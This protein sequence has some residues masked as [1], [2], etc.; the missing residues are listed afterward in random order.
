MESVQNFDPVLRKI[1]Y[2]NEVQVVSSVMKEI[3]NEIVEISEHLERVPPAS[4]EIVEE[5]T[6]RLNSLMVSRCDILSRL[7]KLL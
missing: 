3:A 7:S 2:G 5:H 4:P 6:Q 1:K